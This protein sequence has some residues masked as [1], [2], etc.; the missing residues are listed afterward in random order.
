[1]IGPSLKVV[2]LLRHD[3]SITIVQIGDKNLAIRTDALNEKK[4]GS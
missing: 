4:R 3:E 2:W 1:M